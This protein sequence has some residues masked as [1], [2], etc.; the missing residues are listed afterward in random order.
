MGN[1]LT[2]ERGSQNPSLGHAVEDL[3][4]VPVFVT[5]DHDQVKVGAGLQ[6][7][8]IDTSWSQ[9]MTRSKLLQR[10]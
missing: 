5:P 8:S 10:Q 1:G 3:D 4:R 7:N 6:V 9:M 2:G